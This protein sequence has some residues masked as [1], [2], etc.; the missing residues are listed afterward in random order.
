MTWNSVLPVVLMAHDRADGDE[1]QLTQEF[2]IIRMGR[3]RIAVLDREGLEASACDCYEV[4][5]RRT[6]LLLGG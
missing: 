3:G 2:L 1:F 4:V 6:N 5:K